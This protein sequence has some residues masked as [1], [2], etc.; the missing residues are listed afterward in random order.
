MAA[1]R[2]I[3]ATIKRKLAVNVLMVW[4]GIAMADLSPLAPTPYWQSTLSTL[5][6]TLGALAIAAGILWIA[7]G[8]YRLESKK[9]LTN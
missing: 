2:Q 4:V 5:G 1:R 3:T 8:K 6:I 9:P 7:W